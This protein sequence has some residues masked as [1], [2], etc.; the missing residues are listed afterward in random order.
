MPLLPHSKEHHLIRVLH[1][2][3]FDRFRFICVTCQPKNRVLCRC[4]H[5][6]GDRRWM[7][8][9]F[10][11]FTQM[12][13][14]PCK[15]R[16]QKGYV[17]VFSDM[18]RKLFWGGWQPS[19]KG[20]VTDRTSTYFFGTK[21]GSTTL[22]HNWCAKQ[23]ILRCSH[24]TDRVKSQLVCQSLWQVSLLVFVCLGPNNKCRNVPNSAKDL[25]TK[26]FI[27]KRLCVCVCVARAGLHDASF[28]CSTQMNSENCQN[29]NSVM[30]RITWLG[31]QPTVFI[32][33]AVK[34][35]GSSTT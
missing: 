17:R 13:H 2:R 28:S 8:L 34:H 31:Q 15:Q 7:L 9:S 20:W 4:A 10:T 25:S 16:S 26:P 19:V 1:G 5:S 29:S 14:E 11:L 18:G 24:C 21:S 30:L 32:R 3:R 35:Q 6:C 33:L 27:S 12:G 22:T 23:W